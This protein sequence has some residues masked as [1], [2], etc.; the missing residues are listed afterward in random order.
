LKSLGVASGYQ[1]AKAEATKALR[2][3]ESAMIVADYVFL[4]PPYR[5]RDDYPITLTT[6]ATLNVLRQ[7]SLVVAEHEKKFDPGAEFGRLQ[8]YRKLE[9]GDTALSFYR[10]S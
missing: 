2:Q 3:W 9:Q 1:I 7:S 5:L 4:D 10:C 8:R 6:L